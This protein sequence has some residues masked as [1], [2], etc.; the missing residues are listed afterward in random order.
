MGEIIPLT[1]ARNQPRNF[2]TRRANQE[3]ADEIVAYW[4]ARGWAVKA[5]VIDLSI[6]Q[7]SIKTD[8]INGLPH[9]LY[10]LRCARKAGLR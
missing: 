9:D 2:S 8:M 6:N 3:A 5:E 1:R 10:V 4:A 7:W